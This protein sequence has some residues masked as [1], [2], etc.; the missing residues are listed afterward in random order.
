MNGMKVWCDYCWL[1]SL[2]AVLWYMAQSSPC[3]APSPVWWIYAVSRRFDVWRKQAI[4]EMPVVYNY[5]INHI[6]FHHCAVRM[7]FH[8]DLLHLIMRYGLCRSLSSCP[9]NNSIPVLLG[10]E[11]REVETLKGQFTQNTTIHFPLS[12]FI[13][14]TCSWVLSAEVWR[15]SSSATKRF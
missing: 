8:E 14:L 5:T 1:F 15:S 7:G 3:Y 10:G 11:D 4:G 2:T 9:I 12:L 6:I 13:S